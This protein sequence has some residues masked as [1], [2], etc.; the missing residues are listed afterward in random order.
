MTKRERLEV[1]SNYLL[2]GAVDEEFFD[3]GHWPTCAIG[4]GARLPKFRHEGLMLEGDTPLYNRCAGMYAVAEFFGMKT[5]DARDIFGGH[6]RSRGPED[7][8]KEIRA[9]LRKTAPKKRKAR[10]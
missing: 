5:E 4:E 10:K 2:S 6:E 1:L 8:A 9:Y 3:M 7:V